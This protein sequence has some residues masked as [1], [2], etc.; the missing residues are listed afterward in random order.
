[1]QIKKRDIAVSIV[2]TLVTCGIYG[3]Y[4]VYCLNDDTDRVSNEQNPTDGAIL[5]ILMIVTC[6]I[7]GIYWSYK[8]GERLDRANM[9]RGYVQN[10]RA[11]LYLILSIVGLSIVGYAMMQD[12]LN[13][14]VDGQGGQPPYGQQQP[15]YGQQQ[16][17]YGQ[18]Q[19][20]YQQPPQNNNP[21]QQ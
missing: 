6:G 14:L 19:A 11:I 15:P 5:I 18:Q 16:P 12:E 7:Y 21:N 17:P 4:W 13:K 20:P 10:N 3:I 2:L 1:M 8:Q 9:M